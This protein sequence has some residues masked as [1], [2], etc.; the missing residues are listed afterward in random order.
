MKI[1]VISGSSRING[2]TNDAIQG[3]LENKNFTLINL[4]EKNIAPYKY[5]DQ[6]KD[7][8]E[9]IINQIGEHD[10]ILFA[11]PVYWYCMSG[12]LKNFVDRITGL[13]KENVTKLRDKKVILLANYHSNQSE[14]IEGIFRKICLYLK[15][16][17]IAS[18][19]IS[20]KSTDSLQ[21]GIYKSKAILSKLIFS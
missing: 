20:T 17:Y 11:T 12:L 13:S 19:C 14:S 9:D 16:D 10:I 1:I 15:M 2:R 5:H 3:I 8:F 7:D 6:D 21:D 18:V 4:S